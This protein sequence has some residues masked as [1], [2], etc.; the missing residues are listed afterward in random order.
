MQLLIDFF[1]LLLFFVAYLFQGMSAQYLKEAGE[2]L[3]VRV[4]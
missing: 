3:S 2:K 4:L 1:P